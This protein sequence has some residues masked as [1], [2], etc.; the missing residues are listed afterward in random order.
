MLFIRYMFE[1]LIINFISIKVRQN[2]H[3]SYSKN[4]LHLQTNITTQVRI[5][6]RSGCTKKMTFGPNPSK[7]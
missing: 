1:Y 3:Q 4:K 6:Y 2:L 5:T 7:T